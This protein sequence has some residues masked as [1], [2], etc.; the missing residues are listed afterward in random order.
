MLVGPVVVHDVRG[1]VDD[2]A[3]RQRHHRESLALPLG[4]ALDALDEDQSLCRSVV[5]GI[6]VEDGDRLKI[7]LVLEEDAAIAGAERMPRIRS[8]REA[9]ARQPRA[10]QRERG[11]GEYQMVDRADSQVSR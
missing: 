5:G 8:H 9:E 4:E 3:A 7:R 2:V 1:V 11:N 10:R 6:T